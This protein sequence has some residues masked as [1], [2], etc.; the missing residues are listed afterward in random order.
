MKARNAAEGSDVLVLLADR[1]LQALDLD[2]AGKLRQFLRVDLA[3]AVC[4]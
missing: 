4:V 3:H 2:V 1:L